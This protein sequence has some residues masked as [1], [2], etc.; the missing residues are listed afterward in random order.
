MPLGFAAAVFLFGYFGVLNSIPGFTLWLAVAGMFMG[1][2]LKN[3]KYAIY[4]SCAGAVA[5]FIIGVITQGIGIENDFGLCPAT[6]MSWIV[7]FIVSSIII[8]F[9]FGAVL[10]YITRKS[11]DE[12]KE[13]G[14]WL[15]AVAVVCGLSVVLITGILL[16]QKS[17][18]DVGCCGKIITANEFSMDIHYINHARFGTMQ[19]IEYAMDGRTFRGYVDNSMR[20]SLEWIIGNTRKDSVFL[21]W[22]DY[23]HLIRGYG[24]RDSVVYNP[25]GEVFDR[26]RSKGVGAKVRRTWDTGAYGELSSH[27]K[28]VDVG[29]ALLA[30]TPNETL[31]IMDKYNAGYLYVHYTDFGKSWAIYKAIEDEAGSKLTVN[32]SEGFGVLPTQEEIDEI[33]KTAKNESERQML[34]NEL[35]NKKQF[36]TIENTTIGRALNK[37]EIE[38]LKLVYSDKSA[39]IYER[40]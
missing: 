11:I 36:E 32:F 2:G 8:G 34:I 21:N 25:S 1:L 16:P 28:I 9:L 33:T 19:Y 35:Y 18:E 6:G 4:L 14:T 30:S 39:V 12:D 38:G 26:T 15:L 3:T 37:K 23:G 20:P 10:A 24:G 7:H 17:I 40:I 27:E 31:R 13:T 22:W 29:Y 5:G